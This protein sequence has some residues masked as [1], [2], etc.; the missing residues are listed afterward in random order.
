M[1]RF[2]HFRHRLAAPA[3]PVQVDPTFRGGLGTERSQAG[4]LQYCLAAGL[5]LALVAGGALAAPFFDRQLPPVHGFV[6]ASG[7][8]IVVTNL[9]LATLLFSRGTV[10]AESSAVRL[11]STYLFAA[12]MELPW[13]A[14]FPDALVSTSLIGGRGTPLWLWCLA[15]GGLSL[16]IIRYALAREGVTASVGRS[17]L[18]CLAIVIVL[19]LTA[20]LGLPYL[21]SLLADGHTLF[22]GFGAYI[23]PTLFAL[24]GVALTVLLRDVGRSPIR[25]WLAVGVVSQGFD[26]WAVSHGTTRYSLGWYLAGWGGVLTSLVVLISALHDIMALYQRSAR[27]NE[28]LRSLADLDGLTG[29][30][31]RR[32][33]DEVVDVEWQRARREGAPLSAMMVDV[34][35]FKKFNDH[36]GHLRGDDCLRQIGAALR[37]VARRPADFVARYGGEEF[38]ILLPATDVF[39]A[40]EVA[41]ALHAKLRD[42]A[43]PHAVSPA[44]IVTASV[45]IGTFLTEDDGDTTDLLSR[46]DRNLYLAKQNGRNTTRADLPA[47]AVMAA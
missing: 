15:H 35:F 36:Y 21:P 2:G 38:V 4:R 5:V 20:T 6:A 39:G 30:A 13:L 12:A 45:G 43:M 37:A 1:M 14:A 24:L 27:A 19:T 40:I 47:V 33:F 11:G 7:T 9:L 8:T 29:L 22:T 17:I 18:A 42:L 28:I 46:A 41:Q 25:L 3:E 26:L 31:N 16:G 10:R 23:P 32:R 44:G 34:D